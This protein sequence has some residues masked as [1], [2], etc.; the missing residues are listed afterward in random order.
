MSEH[1]LQLNKYLLNDRQYKEQI[2]E[3]YILDLQHE[4]LRQIIKMLL[5]FFFF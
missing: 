2:R 3:Y 1:K 4:S 5:D